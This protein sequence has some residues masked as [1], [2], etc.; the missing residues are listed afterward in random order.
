MENNSQEE[1]NERKLCKM[2]VQSPSNLVQ[3]IRARPTQAR[4]LTRIAFAAKRYWGYPESW[5]QSWSGVLTVEPEFISAHEVYVAM[6]GRRTVGFYSL[7]LEDAEILL[8]HLWVLPE[9]MRQGIGR[10]L[11]AHA[12]GRVKALGHA[13]LRIEADPNATGFYERVGAR[14]IGA[15][16][17][18]MEGQNRELPLFVYDIGI[19]A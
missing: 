16:I 7:K 17:T 2:R 11:F 10:A 14:R 3:I 6:A 4:A 15:R 12:V 5:I 18:E 1:G 13:S 8:E 19:T 9:M